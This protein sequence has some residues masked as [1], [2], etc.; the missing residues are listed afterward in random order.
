MIVE[1]TNLQFKIG[2][3]AIQDFK[4]R[5]DLIQPKIRNY[6]GFIT[7]MKSTIPNPEDN[8]LLRRLNIVEESRIFF[9]KANELL[10]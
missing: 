10:P 6:D 9:N 5:F 7:K 4:D 3:N 8:N 2:Q 1:E